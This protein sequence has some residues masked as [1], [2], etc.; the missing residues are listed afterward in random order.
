M[1]PN[2]LQV[3]PIDSGDMP[4]IPISSCLQKPAP[5][6]YIAIAYQQKNEKTKKKKKI[7]VN[8]RHP[9]K[10]IGNVVNFSHSNTAFP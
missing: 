4:S 6:K 9:T 8:S 5:Q 3:A 2:S 1:C 10:C 7:T